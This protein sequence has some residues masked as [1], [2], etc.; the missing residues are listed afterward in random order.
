MSELKLMTSQTKPMTS[1]LDTM[2]FESKTTS[3]K[4]KLWLKNFRTRVQCK[5]STLTSCWEKQANLFW[6]PVT[7][8]HFKIRLK[9]SKI[10]SSE[11]II[12]QLNNPFQT[13][14]QRSW[15]SWTVPRWG[16]SGTCSAPKSWTQARSRCRW[17]R[18]RK[19]M[20]RH[21]TESRRMTPDQAVLNVLEEIDIFE[22]KFELFCVKVMWIHYLLSFVACNIVKFYQTGPPQWTFNFK[23]I[24][25]SAQLV[26]N[27]KIATVSKHHDLNFR[28]AIYDPN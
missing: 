8:K 16:D 7:R 13:Q 14:L 22:E 5:S 28:N 20:W 24:W 15:W 19:R 12:R 27:F 1:E 23:L 6:S 18:S 21:T 2:T 11:L 26:L 10:R 17:R 9:E 25:C 3:A 4:T